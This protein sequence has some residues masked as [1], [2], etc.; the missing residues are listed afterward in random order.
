MNEEVMI[1]VKPKWCELI[2]KGKKTIEIRKT[3]PN[4]STPFRGYIY[5]TKSQ[6]LTKSHYD[7][8][9]YVVPDKLK[10]CQ[11]SLELCG[12][13][14]LSGKVIGE[15]VCDRINYINKRGVDN[16][17]DYCFLDPNKWGNDDIEIDIRNVKNSCVDKS[18][19][20]SYGENCNFLYCWHISNLVIYDKP[21]ELSEFKKFNRKCEYGDLGYAKPKDCNKCD[22]CR[23]QKPPQSWCFVEGIDECT[24]L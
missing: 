9:I 21:K 3:K 23:V 8:N 6:L 11:E 7:G 15:F 4:I 17:F 10:K 1:S 14:T 16:N 5:C 20:N 18:E 13:T 12:N 2:A 19:L 24:P 22:G